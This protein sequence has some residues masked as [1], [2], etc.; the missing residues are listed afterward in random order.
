[1]P[2]SIRVIGI[3]QTALFQQSVEAATH[4]EREHKHQGWKADIVRNF[5]YEFDRERTKIVSSSSSSDNDNLADADVIVI[6]SGSTTTVEE[7][8]NNSAE[9][10]KP[11]FSFPEPKILSGEDFLTFVCENSDFRVFNDNNNDKEDGS[12]YLSLARAQYRRFLKASGCHFAWMLIT[13][14]DV[15]LGRIVFQLFTAKAPRTCQNFLYLCRGD[16]PDV[17][18]ATIVDRDSGKERVEPKIKLSYKNS[19]V[20]RVVQNGWIQAGDILEPKLGNGGYSVY[21]RHFPDETFEVEHSDEGILGMA[22]DG[23][24]TNASSFYITMQPAAWMNKRYVAFGRAVEG[25]KVLRALKA[26]KTK[27]NQSPVDDVIIADCGEISM[28]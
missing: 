7:E 13:H 15:P 12:S 11:A 19:R 28:D 27:H 3:Q 16:L 25:V 1:M 23:E 10:K 22:N 24:H 4:L 26:L 20:F 2:V 9:K 8:N 21:G 17:E 18:N 5:E 14:N 6:L